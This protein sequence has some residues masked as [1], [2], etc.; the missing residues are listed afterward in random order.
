VS[1]AAPTV[2]VV[3]PTYNRRAA[4]P[5][6]LDPILREEGLLEIVLAVDGSTDGTV[7][8]LRRLGDD[9]LV[10]LDLPNR[11]AGG[12]RQA[13][14][15][16]ARGDVVVLLD[17]D[18]VV[19]PRTIAGHARHHA[20]LE[21]KLVLGYMPNDWRAVPADRRAIAYVYRRAYELHC[22]RFATDPDFV[23]N[24]LWGGNLSM[25]REDMLRV[26]IEKLAVKRG[27]DD[28]E[29]GLRCLKAGI[30]G[31][32]D[33]SL[34]ALHLYDRSFEAFR[35]DCRIQGESRRLIRAAHAELVGD[36]PGDLVGTG[37]PAPLRSVWP[38]L[39]REPLFGAL[40]GGMEALFR[41]GLRRRHLGLEVFA[42]R[43]IGSLETMR[44]VLGVC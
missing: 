33:P 24:G 29:F 16:A 19:A 35:R 11:G 6:F 7:E 34:A 43:G 2:S 5:G 27:Q 41:A 4:L 9:R 26:G 30:R 17:D 21:P 10:V 39:A 23:L 28:R 32:Y 13:G 18:V 1:G 20:G 38:L 36:S 31:V 42:A 25:P 3:A 44:G 14:L 40:S 8:W 22:A 37:L 15:E 12:A